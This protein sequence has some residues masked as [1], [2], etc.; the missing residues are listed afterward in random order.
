MKKLL[1]VLVVAEHR[2]MGAVSPLFNGDKREK[3]SFSAIAVHQTIDLPTLVTGETGH[4]V[5]RSYLPD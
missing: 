1:R 4:F 3:Q 5:G 2:M